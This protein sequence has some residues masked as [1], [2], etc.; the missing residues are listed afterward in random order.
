M[1]SKEKLI[2]YINHSLNKGFV[3]TLLMDVCHCF[4]NHIT[5]SGTFLQHWLCSYKERVKTVTQPE[6]TAFVK[7]E[8]MA[9]N[10]QDFISD[11]ELSSLRFCFR[12]LS[13]LFTFIFFS[14]TTNNYTVYLRLVARICYVV[15]FQANKDKENVTC[16]QCGRNMMHIIVF[17]FF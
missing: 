16:C 1:K 10:V 7:K 14:S 2:K 6:N 11:M 13:Y 8:K 5:S 9:G 17:N 15:L 12:N 4:V 3:V